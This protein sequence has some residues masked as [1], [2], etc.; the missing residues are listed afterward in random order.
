MWEELVEILEREVE[1]HRELK[2]SLKQLRESVLQRDNTRLEEV[3][4]FQSTIGSE[5]QS[6]E[7]KRVELCRRLCGGM[8]KG[9]SFSDLI[10]IS[11]KAIRKV[12]SHRRKE[13][14]NLVK[15]IQ[16]EIRVMRYVIRT[17]IRYVEEMISIFMAEELLVYDCT[18]SKVNRKGHIYSASA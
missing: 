5:I 2:K 4:R 13:M 7:E 1:L 6:L 12:L 10:R 8:E 14:V 11:P 17:I 15:E 3:L 16:Q 9:I 18:G